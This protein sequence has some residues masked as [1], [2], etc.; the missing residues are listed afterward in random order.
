MNVTPL[1]A[2]PASPRIDSDLSGVNMQRADAK[3]LTPS[4]LR[5]ASAADQ[6][7]AAGAQFEA[8]LV[9]QLLGKTLTSMLGSREGTAATIYGDLLAETIAS[10]LSAGRGLG[11]GRMLEAQLTPRGEPAPSPETRP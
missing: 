9:R 5:R 1:N 8:I 6:R 4:A 7:A 3:S 2:S 10:Q 11:L